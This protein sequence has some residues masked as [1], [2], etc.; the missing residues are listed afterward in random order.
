MTRKTRGSS[1]NKARGWIY[2]HGISQEE[3]TR[4]LGENPL[5][6][7]AKESGSLTVKAPPEVPPIRGEKG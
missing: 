4:I 1:R 7:P 2:D 6:P 3:L 5:S